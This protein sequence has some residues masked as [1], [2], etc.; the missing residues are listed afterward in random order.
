MK[1]VIKLP[2]SGRGHSFGRAGAGRKT[3]FADR[4][5]VNRTTARLRWRKDI[6]G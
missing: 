5:R 6:E 3:Y 1:I 2:L 4:R